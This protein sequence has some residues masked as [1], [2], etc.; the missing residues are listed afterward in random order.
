LNIDSIRKRSS[1]TSKTEMIA[2][3]FTGRPTEIISPKEISKE[4]GLDLQLVTSIV[5]RLMDEGLIDRISRGKYRLG[6]EFMG[7][8]EDIR[9]ICDDLERVALT[10]L[11]SKPRSDLAFKKEADPYKRLNEIFIF[12]KGVGGEAMA[13]NLLRISS[14]KRLDNDQT[15]MLFNILKGVGN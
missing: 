10:T 3:V 5:K 15:E 13:L 1:K 4:L 7:D 8:V 6:S 11:G 12:I 2:N 14:K 9:S